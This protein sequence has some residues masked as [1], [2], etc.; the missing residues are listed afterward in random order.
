MRK[1]MRRG[2]GENGIKGKMRGGGESVLFIV[3]LRKVL[4]TIDQ[5]FFSTHS[6]AYVFYFLN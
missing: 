3:L 6:F 5:F 1:L 2:E 4:M